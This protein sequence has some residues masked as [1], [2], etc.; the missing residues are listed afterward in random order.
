M[1]GCRAERST[2]TGRGADG[3]R[4]AGPAGP[5]RKSRQSAGADD[6][7]PPP[8]ARPAGGDLIV[9]RRTLTAWIAPPVLALIATAP[10]P[11]IVPGTGSGALA[12][13]PPLDWTD[14]VAM[15]PCRTPL[16][17]RIT[18]EPG[19]PRDAAGPAGSP[20]VVAWPGGS[21]PSWTMTGPWPAGTW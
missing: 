11:G 16:T 12:G 8:P 17:G 13:G 20:A 1:C 5:P 14:P 21:A 9:Q 6:R 15:T 2:A 4:H 10:L 3:S 18:G 19:E 7:L